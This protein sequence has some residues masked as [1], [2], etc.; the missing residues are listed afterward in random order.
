[1]SNSCAKKSGTP[2]AKE[3]QTDPGSEKPTTNDQAP[4]IEQR[5]APRAT[6]KLPMRMEM[7]GGIEQLETEAINISRSGA[8]V[9]MEIPFAVGT[10]FDLHLVLADGQQLFQ[11]TANVVRCQ[12]DRKPVGIG[13]RFL[14]LPDAAGSLIDRL[15]SDEARFG[16]FHIEKLIGR[17][18]MA[19]V[20]L[21]R[22]LEGEHVGQ[23]VALKRLLPELNADPVFVDLF[24]SEADVTRTLRHAGIVQ[25]LETG[26][27]GDAYYIAMEYVE[28]GNLRN[29]LH[30]L[31]TKNTY[32]PIVLACHI[33]R[34][35]AESL[36]YAHNA[37]SPSGQ[38]YGLVHCDVAPSNIFV[39]LDGSVKLSDFGVAQVKALP[40]PV[41][42]QVLVGR[43][44]Y[45]APEQIKGEPLSPATD[46]FALGAVFYEMLTHCH[47]FV[48]DTPEQIH[49]RI[50]RGD[51]APASSV[52]KEI[53]EKLD[54]IVRQALG[55][56]IAGS[57]KAF[58]SRGLPLQ[59]RV[60]RY[61]DAF[62]FLSDLEALC[63]HKEDDQAALASF[64]SRLAN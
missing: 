52:R 5:A 1:M 38:P 33:T 31:Q 41:E 10:T 58:L 14:N 17:G 39:G 63:T 44:P 57:R 19:E 27:V 2:G 56:N 64:V 59:S 43:A 53:P 36:H 16:K 48:G 50:L 35:V 54:H 6:I 13:V 26:A 25:V 62:S 4:A 29:L 46:V 9:A 32:L 37:C 30:L 15:L 34:M 20:F 18:G 28:G 7:P 3:A 23:C 22:V 8:F 45:R 49:R 61:P 11:V 21:A 42:G 12:M 55:K 40:G 51:V 24:V 47:A 60:Q